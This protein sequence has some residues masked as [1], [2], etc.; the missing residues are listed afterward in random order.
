MTCPKDHTASKWWSQDL[1][2]GRLIQQSM[3]YYAH[4]TDEETLAQRG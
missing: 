4:F 3:G 2:M 1:N